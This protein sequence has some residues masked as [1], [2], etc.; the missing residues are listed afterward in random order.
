M[1]GLV[2]KRAFVSV[3][4]KAK[5]FGKSNI[6]TGSLYNRVNAKSR[7]NDVGQLPEEFKEPGVRRYVI[8]QGI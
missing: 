8:A 1:S 4:E 7:N 5:N 2:T 3:G 6:F